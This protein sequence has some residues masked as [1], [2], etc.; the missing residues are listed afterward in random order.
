L[1]YFQL[2][3]QAVG[4]IGQ[5]SDEAAQY[6]SGLLPADAWGVYRGSVFQGDL[7]RLF[8]A[9]TLKAYAICGRP[10]VP[11]KINDF[12][13]RSAIDAGNVVDAAFF[14]WYRK[15]YG[16][17]MLNARLL[18]GAS[19]ANLIPLFYKTP[20]GAKWKKWFEANKH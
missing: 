15:K 14:D 16:F 3:L 4:Y 2:L 12:A 10:D 7:N 13:T 9:F 1:N 6:L 8:A 18:D 20:E 19:M 11:D 5:T 17:E